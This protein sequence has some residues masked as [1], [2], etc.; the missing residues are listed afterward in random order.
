MSGISAS[1]SSGLNKTVATR[2]RGA[3]RNSVVAMARCVESIIDPCGRARLG[4]LSLPLNAATLLLK[5]LRRTSRSHQ[6]L[7]LTSDHQ[8]GTLTRKLRGSPCS[9]PLSP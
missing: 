7:G 6:R 9:R 8:T 2:Q 3:L 5:L 4:P 1:T